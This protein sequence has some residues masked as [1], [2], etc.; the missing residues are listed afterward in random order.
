MIFLFAYF[1]SMVNSLISFLLLLITFLIIR[2]LL[3]YIVYTNAK[4]RELDNPVFWGV[5]TLFAGLV[6]LILYFSFNIKLGKKSKPKKKHKI[7]VAS[8]LAICLCLVIS[9]GVI[10]HFHRIEDTAE[11]CDSV[12]EKIAPYKYVT[13]DKNG[14]QYDIM[15]LYSYDYWDSECSKENNIDIYDRNGKKLDD[16]IGIYVDS[17]GYGISELDAKDFQKR[18]YENDYYLYTVYFDNE[19]NIYYDDEDCSWDKNGKLIFK[20]KIFEK[21]T[22]ENTEPYEEK[23][24]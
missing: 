17:D 10:G 15:D 3:S 14:R 6:S 23:E 16:E 18:C 12:V 1:Y 11:N 20:D 13:Y 7:I 2:V 5:I 8:A 22:Y 9:S 4:R 21:L 24:F 19:H